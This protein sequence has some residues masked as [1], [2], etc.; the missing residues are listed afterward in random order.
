M[1]KRNYRITDMTGK[2]VKIKK[3]SDERLSKLAYSS[4]RR[5]RKA[6]Y[7]LL[8]VQREIKRRRLE[9]PAHMVNCNPL[10]ITTKIL[11]FAHNDFNHKYQ[12][13]DDFYGKEEEC[14]HLN[15]S[16][17]MTGA[18]CNDCGEEE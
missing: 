8:E 4:E 3:L 9:H 2:Q 14:Q 11:A 7:E 12:A 5:I 1:K 15:Y 13:E 17:T 6:M 18:V 10:D 16:D